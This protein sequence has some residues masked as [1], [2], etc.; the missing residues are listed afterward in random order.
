MARCPLF[1]TNKEDVMKEKRP[2]T[3]K[4]KNEAIWDSVYDMCDEDRIR[5]IFDNEKLLCFLEEN[6]INDIHE[7]NIGYSCGFPILIDFSGY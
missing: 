7:G 5:A 3:A 1:L 6:N 2:M 4:Q